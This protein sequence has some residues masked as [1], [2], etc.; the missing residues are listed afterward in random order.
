MNNIWITKKNENWQEFRNP[1]VLKKI[2]WNP[3]GRYGGWFGVRQDFSDPIYHTLGFFS[4]GNDKF[5]PSAHPSTTIF[6]Y[7]MYI[8]LTTAYL[9]SN[10]TQSI[11]LIDIYFVIPLLNKM[12]SSNIDVLVCCLSFQCHL[13][14]QCNL[15]V[16][17]IL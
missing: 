5:H 4:H 8:E 16:I 15:S 11:N 6:I 13:Q 17:K 9:M 1:F 2:I 14:P 7:G 3:S 10:K 12:F